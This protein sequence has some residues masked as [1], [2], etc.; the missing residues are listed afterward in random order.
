[1]AYQWKGLKFSQFEMG[2][3][4]TTASRTITEAD[5]VNFAGISGDYYPLHTNEEFAKETPFKTRIGHGALSFAVATGLGNQL[6]IFEGTT[7]ALMSTLT[8]YTGAVLPGD[9]VTMTMTVKETKPSSKGGRGV[10]T[11]TTV[12]NKQTGDQVFEGEWVLMMRD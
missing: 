4:Y 8:K 3:A 2:Q 5:I 7:L 9:T 12:L 10:V 11:F 6:G 1:M